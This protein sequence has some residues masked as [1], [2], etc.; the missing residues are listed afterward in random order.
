MSPV[1]FACGSGDVVAEVGRGRRF[2]VE[3]IWRCESVGE[4]LEPFDLLERSTGS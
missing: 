4:M 2:V 1:T 3:R